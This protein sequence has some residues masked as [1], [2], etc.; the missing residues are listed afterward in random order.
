MKLFSRQY[1]SLIKEFSLVW[2]QERDQRTFLGMIW[3]FFNPLIVTLIL[4]LIF[5]HGLANNTF[6][7]GVRGNNLFFLYIL[8][9]VVAWNFFTSAVQSNISVLLWR[10][11]IVKNVAFPKEIL[12]FAQFGVSLIQYFF[13]IIIVLIF[14]LILKGGISIHLIFLP[15]IIILESLLII[16][17]GLLLSILCVY[18]QDLEYVWRTITS[19]GFFLTPIFYFI[20]N[21]PD[22][23]KLIVAINPLTQLIFFYR[24]VL[25]DHQYPNYF[26][27]T[28]LLICDI[29]LLIFS[30]IFF[31]RHEKKIAEKV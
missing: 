23:L 20:N 5:Q 13:E 14:I 1:F 31:K 16:G 26:N 30:F 29:L 22:K 7:T 15:I 25:I 18:A 17:L 21:L 28:I 6:L 10:Q 19:I 24:N 8:I 11:D 2:F 9:G 3:N 4:Y 27:L 12:I